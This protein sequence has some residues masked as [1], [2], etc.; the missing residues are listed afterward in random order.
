M[1]GGVGGPAIP[2]LNRK[3]SHCR[4]FS[5]RSVALLKVKK[6]SKT[7]CNPSPHFYVVPN[8]GSE[9]TAHSTIMLA[10]A[11]A[12]KHSKALQNFAVYCQVATH[13]H[14]LCGYALVYSY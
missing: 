7:A 5:P 2:I 9:F 8:Y 3:F 11:N 10:N 4:I 13:L 12:H 1:G 14:Q 6:P